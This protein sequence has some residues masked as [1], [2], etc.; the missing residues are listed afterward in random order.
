MEYFE[1][2][3]R[4]VKQHELLTICHYCSEVRER[5]KQK[6]WAKTRLI[7]TFYFM[8]RNSDCVRK[9]DGE[10][11]SSDVVCSYFHFV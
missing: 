10:V 11:L 5:K 8:L 2:A 1:A 3:G 4:S 6:E 7:G 9:A